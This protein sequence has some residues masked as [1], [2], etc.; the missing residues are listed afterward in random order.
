MESTS[1]RQIDEIRREANRRL[2]PARKSELGQFMTSSAIA[3]FMASRFSEFPAK[4]RLL[5]P[6]AGVGS[7]TEAFAQR[8]LTLSPQGSALEVEAYEIDPVLLDYLGRQLEE[9]A[10]RAESQHR[11]LR[12]TV[13]NRD[14]VEES[15]FALS[16]GQPRFTHAI[17]NPPYK[18]IGSHSN[19]RR[20][21]SALGI[22]T[23][24]L[25]SA[26][27]ALA[28][29]HVQDQGEIVA[30][31]P[32]SF[33]NGSYF[34]PFRQWLLKRVAIRQVHVFG[35]RTTPFQEDDVLQENV[36]VHLERSGVQG[37]VTVSDSLDSRFFDYTER[38]AAFEEIVKP[39]DP[40]SFIRIPTRQI[41]CPPSLFSHS[42]SELSLGVSTGPVVDFRVRE[43]WVGEPIADCA[44]LLYAH[45]FREGRLVWPRQHKKPNAVRVN[46]G[47]RK[48]LMPRGC[49]TVTKRFSAKEE[50]KRLVAYVVEPDLLPYDLYGFENHLNVFHEAKGGIARD[51]ARGLAVFLNS[52]VADMHFRD[53]S[54]H[55]QVNA[56]DLRSMRYPSRELLLKFGARARGRDTIGQD[57]MDAIVEGHN[58]G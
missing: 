26:F 46:E 17:L 23:V 25:Y 44:P 52:T 41:D 47:T 14:F 10:A 15:T 57:E 32:R 42:L 16:F 21:L 20:L 53:F 51:L 58:G 1:N 8:F 22:E 12:F 29:A 24:N 39:G 40:E 48:W 33:C 34:R 37:A 5:D 7:L 30:I 4:V 13:H 45:H 43:H 27:L 6:G 3:D 2:D 56:T 54:G 55:T 18:K 35:S 31:V 11:S 9:L 49:Y 19:H 28:I 36:I 50:R 38:K